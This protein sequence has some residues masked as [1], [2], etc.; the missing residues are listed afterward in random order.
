[1]PRCQGGWWQCSKA[2]SVFEGI[3]PLLAADAHSRQLQQAMN[4]MASPWLGCSSGRLW[5]WAS[6][7]LLHA[8]AHAH[9][10]VNQ[11]HQLFSACAPLNADIADNVL[12]AATRPPHV[13]IT[14]LMVFATYQSSAKG[15]AR[16]LKQ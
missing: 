14:D 1:M 2:D 5:H 6:L 10:A 7:R 8:P 3:H 12:Y 4:G 9:G 11:Q 13:Q 15:L 16:V